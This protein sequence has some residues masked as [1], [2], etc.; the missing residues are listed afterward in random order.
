MGGL[1]NITE[2]KYLQ[3][4]YKKFNSCVYIR[5]YGVKLVLYLHLSI[6]FI[7]DYQHYPNVWQ[8]FLHFSYMQASQA[9]LEALYRI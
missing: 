2:R 3:G 8:D 6:L 7:T 5:T 9:N 1:N 4:K